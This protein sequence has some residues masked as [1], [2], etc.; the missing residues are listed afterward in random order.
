M[1]DT[2]V[3]SLI[4]EAV[5]NLLEKENHEDVQLT[6]RLPKQL[7]DRLDA[8]RKERSGFVSRNQALIEAIS[9]YEK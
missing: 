4:R 9:A 5:T 6:V 1:K 8:N 3:S 2:D 7:V